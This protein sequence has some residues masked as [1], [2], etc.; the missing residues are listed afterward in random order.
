VRKRKIKKTEKFLT[1]RFV[2][3][4][5]SVTFAPQTRKTRYLG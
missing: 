2:D 4:E 5:K 3:S 1:E